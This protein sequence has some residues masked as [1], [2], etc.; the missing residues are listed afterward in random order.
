MRPKIPKSATKK[1]ASNPDPEQNKTKKISLQQK[2][3][4]HPH[5]DLIENGKIKCNLTGH[6]LEP[7]KSNFDEYLKSKSYK[8]ALES[9]FDIT[10]YEEFLV[11]HK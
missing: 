4:K 5:F 6:E 7:K 2:V 9:Q 8:R 10:E 1:T 3:A 11:D